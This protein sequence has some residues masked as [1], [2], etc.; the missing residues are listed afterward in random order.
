[1]VARSSLIQA[2][3][4]DWASLRCGCGKTGAHIP[5]TFA[6]LLVAGMPQEMANAYLE[7]HVY[8]QSLLSEVAVPVTSMIMAA[9]G[10]ETSEA[11]RLRLIDE[12]ISCVGGESHWTE[13]GAGAPELEVDCQIVA[14]EGIWTLNQEYATGRASMARMILD[15]VDIDR[16]RFE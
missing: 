11:V 7:G 5:E 2:E 9:L 6:S 14:R 15:A 8:I 12:L 13:V 3:R 4:V 10:E 1:M 16:D